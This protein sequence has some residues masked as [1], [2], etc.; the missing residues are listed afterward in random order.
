MKD[1]PIFN[2]KLAGAINNALNA[3]PKEEPLNWDDAVAIDKEISIVLATIMAHVR[4]LIKRPASVKRINEDKNV[5]A[6][7]T[8]FNKGVTAMLSEMKDIRTIVNNRTGVATEGDVYEL[9][10]IYM[11]YMTISEKADVLRQNITRVFSDILSESFKD[12]TDA[13]DQDKMQAAADKLK[14]EMNSSGSVEE[15]SDAGGNDNGE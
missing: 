1:K 8:I 13:E 10:S 6:N 15:K 9:G 3:P 12:A 7:V 4:K 11:K 14:S 2:P 5:A